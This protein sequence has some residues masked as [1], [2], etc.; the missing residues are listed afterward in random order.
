MHHGSG[1]ETPR[2]K[3]F[4]ARQTNAL[5]SLGA[6]ISAQRRNQILLMPGP[7]RPPKPERD[8]RQQVREAKAAR[9]NQRAGDESRTAYSP[10]R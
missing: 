4:Q 5:R 8:P 6:R 1:I 10:T 9:R 3:F 7:V 2:A